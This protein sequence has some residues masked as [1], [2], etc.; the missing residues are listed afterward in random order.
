MIT[1]RGKCPHCNKQFSQGRAM[2][3]HLMAKHGLSSVEAHPIANPN[4]RQAKR[5]KSWS[6]KVPPMFRPTRTRDP[7]DDLILIDEDDIF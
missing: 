1:G 7:E 5:R 2:Q 4:D 6:R 3:H